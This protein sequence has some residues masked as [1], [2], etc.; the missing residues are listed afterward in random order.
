M[1]KTMSTVLLLATLLAACS[2]T[3]DEAF[4]A[5]EA[6]SGGAAGA[7]ATSALKRWAGTQSC[8]G[9]GDDSKAIDTT[10]AEAFVDSFTKTKT[11]VAITGVDVGP[12]DAYSC[13]GLSFHGV[14]TDADTSHVSF[15]AATED[16]SRQLHCSSKTGRALR[17]GWLRG[18]DS[19]LSQ[20]DGPW[21]LHF[22]VRIEEPTDDLADAGVRIS[23][24][25]IRCDFDF[26]FE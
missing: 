17:V 25:N 8:T 12:T 6:L 15:E 20:L 10:S 5:N 24:V 22:R 1:T 2:G 13:A 9:S 19:D 23:R 21:N 26:T 11:R 18:Y 14:V 4:L 16:A 3:S 7:G